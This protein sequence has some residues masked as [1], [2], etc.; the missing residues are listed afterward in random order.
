MVASDWFM[1]S[2][3]CEL[4][5]LLTQQVS[6]NGPLQVDAFRAVLFVETPAN[7]GVHV[8][9]E[10]LQLLPQGL[11]VFF[12]CRRFVQGAPEGS[13]VSVACGQHRVNE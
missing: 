6:R 10:W 12:K 1:S 9:I 11:Q 3:T 7:I 2:H 5:S 4:N 8:L 13:G